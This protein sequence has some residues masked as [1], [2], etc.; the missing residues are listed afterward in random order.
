MRK[1]RSTMFGATKDVTHMIFSKQLR[2]H[3]PLVMALYVT[4]LHKGE[5]VLTVCKPTSVPVHQCGQY[6]KSTAVRIL[7]AEHDMA[8]LFPI[9]RLDPGLLALAGSAYQA[10]IL[11]QQNS[12]L[13]RSEIARARRRYYV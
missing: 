9:H 6:S 13:P 10:Q 1:R 12:R 11:R 7:Q 2:R 8:H 5:V 4:I 3:E